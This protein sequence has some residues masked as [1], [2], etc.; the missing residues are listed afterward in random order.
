MVIA[1]T[2]SLFNDTGSSYL[3]G[4]V[5][6]RREEVVRYIDAATGPGRECQYLTLA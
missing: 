5:R 1:K 4:L 2:L 3:M 6:R